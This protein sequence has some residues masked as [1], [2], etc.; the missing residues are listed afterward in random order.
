MLT[1]RCPS[2]PSASVA[3]TLPP[4]SPRSPRSSI[5]PLDCSLPPRRVPFHFR[6]IIHNT[7][8]YLLK[9]FKLTDGN[10][11]NSLISAAIQRGYDRG[12]FDLPKGAGGKVLLSNGKEVS[13][14]YLP[15]V[16]GAWRISRDGR[17]ASGS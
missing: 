7:I 16:R 15:V 12:V 5:F 8:R 14:D 3:P 6:H 11:F 1:R 4:S 9:T 2:P 13:R 17:D 10:A